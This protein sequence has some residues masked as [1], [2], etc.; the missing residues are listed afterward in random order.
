MYPHIETTDQ[1]ISDL[2]N[3]NDI[4]I[5]PFSS[6][7]AIYLYYSSKPFILIRYYSGL[8]PSIFRNFKNVA[9]ATNVMELDFILDSITNNNYSII[10]MPKIL[11]TNRK[12]LKWIRLL[13][14]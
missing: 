11:D 5:A 1:N 12:L 6:A 13:K 3:Q 10:N 4:F 8:D 9:S 14:K 7:V 2:I